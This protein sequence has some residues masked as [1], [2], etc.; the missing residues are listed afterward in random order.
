MA[1]CQERWVLVDREMRFHATD[2]LDAP[3]K[4]LATAPADDITLPA[5]P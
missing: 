4:P 1:G 3:F 2:R 5:S